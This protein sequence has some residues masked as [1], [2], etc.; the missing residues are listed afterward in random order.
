MCGLLDRHFQNVT[1]ERF[2]S[3]LAEKEWVL[4]L[5]QAEVLEGFST[6]MRLETGPVVAFFSGDTIV[7]AE[8]RSRLDLPRLWGRHVFGL[9]QELAPREV[10]W[11]LICSGYRTYRF[12]PTF[13]REFFPRF[14][15]PTPPATARLLDGLCR[16]KFPHGYEPATGVVRLEHPAP[17]KEE[18]AEIPARRMRDPHVA[19]Y[20]RA[21]PGYARGD[22]LACI[23]RVCRANLTPA[24]LRMLE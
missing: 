7:S 18:L 21:N 22:E 9:A 23:V 11:F 5:Y 10:Y 20:A 4:L 6:L 17:L 3:D 1:R 8:A 13:F 16:Q 14:D 12:L 2:E 19:F 24:G 15:Q